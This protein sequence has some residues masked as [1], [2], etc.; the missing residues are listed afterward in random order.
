MANQGSCLCGSLSWEF[1]GEPYQA[2]NCHCKMCRKCHG[3]AFGTYWFLEQEQFNWTCDKSSLVQFESSTL[4][5]RNFCGR[6]GSVAPYPNRTGEKIVVPAGC[7]DTGKKSDCNIFVADNAPWHP[8][9]NGLPNYDHYPPWTASGF[10]AEKDPT[11]ASKGV[12]RSSCQCG[13]IEC[14]IT[15]P[16]SIVRNCHC[17]RCRR[18]RSAAYTTNGFTSLEGVS[19]IRGEEHLETYKLPGAKFFTQA[20]CKICGSK[21]PRIDKDRGITLTP[22]G[23]LDDDP[24]TQAQ[25]HIYVGSKAQWHD[26]TDGLPE[27][28]A[29]PS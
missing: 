18:A 28:T 7:H 16:F 10:V 1:T 19:Y 3:A 12:V 22:L 8:I 9:T 4:L 14:R 17:S 21:M 2:F 6:C 29:G 25:E 27:F 20:F 15:E 5:T 23:S 26:I 24:G 13:A 11:P